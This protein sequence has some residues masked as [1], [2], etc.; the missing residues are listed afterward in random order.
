VRAN[1]SAINDCWNRI[2]V[3]GDASC[4]QLAQHTHC[5]NCPTYA[6]AAA[7]ILDRA[8]PGQLAPLTHAA[9]EEQ[10]A[11]E[12]DTHSV[13]VFRIGAEWLALATTVFQEIAVLRAIHSV[14]QRRTGAVL[15]LVNV[16]G[17]LLVCLSLEY[18]LGLER[19]VIAQPA[20]P[21][22]AQKRLLVMKRA[23]QLAVCPV[24][25][26]IGIESFHKRQ[27]RITPATL[28]KSGATYTNAVLSWRH[29]L[30]AVLDDE[31]LFHTF[32]RSLASTI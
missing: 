11:V 4:S 23:G 6:A 13:V 12:L 7:D 2:G 14:P 24:D 18:I 31:L 19:A 10:A 15:G 3:R 16:R 8:V 28:S 9:A 1:I 26:V 20:Q 5:R 32:N 27:L 25:E 22:T 17:E 29:K 21:R 30:V